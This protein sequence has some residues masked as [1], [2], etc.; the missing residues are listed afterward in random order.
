MLFEVHIRTTTEILYHKVA[1]M[2]R[3]HYKSKCE[4][5]YVHLIIIKG[6]LLIAF[7]FVA[8]ISLTAGS[9]NLNIEQ[10]DGSCKHVEIICIYLHQDPLVSVFVIRPTNFEC[11]EFRRKLSNVLGAFLFV[12]FSLSY[13]CQYK[14]LFK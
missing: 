2:E 3:K 4:P 8:T 6:I 7:T 5:I 9:S 12:V 1:D 10:K 14:E 13:R 11:V